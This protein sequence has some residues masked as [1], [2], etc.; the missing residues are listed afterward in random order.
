MQIKPP[1][2]NSRPSVGGKSI[3]VLLVDDSAVVRGLVSRWLGAEPGIEVIAKAIDGV[4]GVKLAEQYKPDIIVLD[5]EMPRMDGLTALPQ[6]LKGSPKSKVI[7]A[8][9][10]TH[11]NADITLRALSQGA[12]DY[13]PKPETGKLAGAEEFRINLIGKIRALG[14]TVVFKARA[15]PRAPI[16]QI[17]AKRP[18]VFAKPQAI[19]VG[20]STGGPQAL[21]DLMSIIGSRVNLPIFITQHM[22]KTFTAVL[23]E[24]LSK[25]AKKLVVEG[26]DGMP[27]KPGGVYLAPG[28]YHMFVRKSGMGVVIGLDQKPPE[29]YCRPSVNPMFRSAVSVYGNSALAVMLT[30]MGQDGL[31]G[32]Q[33]MYDAGSMVIAQD[34]ASSVV[35]GMPGAIA[36]AG[37]AH[38]ILPMAKIGPKILQIVQRK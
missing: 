10:L 13:T 37:L 25:S 35:W 22:P 14:Q 38:E 18:A 20:S 26:R 32:T 16:A 6:I 2:A 8:S 30:G 4:Q 17:V 29:N 27:V 3:S 24:H 11:R 12:S 28:D 21:R 19:F 7:M 31:S 9:T 34:E 36:K 23:A 15:V 33:E 5:I 1:I